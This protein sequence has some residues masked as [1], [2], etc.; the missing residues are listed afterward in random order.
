M[1]LNENLAPPGYYMIHILANGVP[2]EAKIIQI[3]GTAPPP[4]QATPTLTLI[5]PSAAQVFA[6]PASGFTINVAGSASDNTV[7][8]IGSVQVIGPNGQPGAVSNVSGNWSSWTAIVNTG[9]S[10]PG[11][12]Q[13]TIKATATD[14][15]GNSSSVTIPIKISFM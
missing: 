14:L 12:V 4:D 15:S 3:P 9:S 11:M 13:R 10:S 1:P 6:G 7:N 8:G 2:S 5:S